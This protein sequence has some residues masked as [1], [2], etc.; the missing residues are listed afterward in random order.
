MRMRAAMEGRIKDI[1]ATF[2]QSSPK[3]DGGIR[4][5]E[6]SA[7]APTIGSWNPRLR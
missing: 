6:H 3:N 1:G 5:L 2:L 7:L 4:L